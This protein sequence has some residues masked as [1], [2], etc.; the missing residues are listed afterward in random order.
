MSIPVFL[1]WHQEA[2]SDWQR[3]KSR[4]AHAWLI[5]GVAGTGKLEFARAAAASLLCESPQAGQACGHCQA[6]Q[7][8]AGGNH[9]DLKRIRPD[10]VAQI[11]G[12][13]DEGEEGDAAGEGEAEGSS[14]SRKKNP[15]KEIR[16]EQI[17]A[18]ES[19]FHLATHRGGWRVVLLYPADALNTIAANA[20]L[21]ILEEPPEHTV[22]LLVVDAPDRL[23]PTLVSRCRK[24]PLPA[25]GWDA[26]LDWLQQQELADAPAW[27]AAAGGAPLQAL[28][29]SRQQPQPVPAWLEQAIQTLARNQQP[30]I[31]QLAEDL[32]K[33]PPALWLDTLQRFYIDLML[34][35]HGQS[36]R[37]YPSHQAALE[38]IAGR[39]PA[40]RLSAALQWLS[41][42]RRV[43]GH[44]LNARLWLHTVLQNTLL[45]SA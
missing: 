1:P 10:S 45:F 44:P 9:P 25:P 37:Y 14:A 3:Q 22:F 4:F 36:V 6:C 17:R 32:D 28:R 40:A 24:L 31:G 30:D 27:L 7:W 5:H 18:L 12:Q 23:L 34:A 8:V 29:L 42:Q 13:A 11:E 16:L 39:M 38:G 2:L 19:W 26:A 21:K 41:Q 20:L 43:A 15:S 35:A 33:Q